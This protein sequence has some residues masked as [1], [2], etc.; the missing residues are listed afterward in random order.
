[1]DIRFQNEIH[2]LET[3]PRFNMGKFLCVD[4]DA[5]HVPP[6]D[7]F[8]QFERRLIQRQYEVIKALERR[9]L[10]DAQELE[11]KD[12]KMTQLEKELEESCEELF[13]RVNQS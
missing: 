4:H 1:M 10:Q 5:S 8:H 3:T 13:L 6:E 11:D 12:R 9:I 2:G 7:C